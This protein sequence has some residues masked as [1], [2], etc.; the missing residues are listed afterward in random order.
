MRL[1]F[2]TTLSFVLCTHFLSAE[3]KQFM[4]PL[5]VPAGFTVEIAARPPLVEH[6]MLACFDDRGRLFIAESDGQNLKKEELL[7]QRP[8]FVRLLEDTDGDG[9]FDKST[10]FA[11]KMTMPEG[12]LWHDGALYIISAPYLWRLKDTDDD[13]VCDEREKLLGYMEFDGRANQHGPFLGPNGRLYITGGHFGVDFQAKDGSKVGAGH[14]TAG[15]FSCTLDGNDVQV[16]GLG[17]INPV[18]IIFTPE[19]EMISTNAI[20]DSVGGRHD[21]LVHWIHGGLTQRVYGPAYIPDTGVR[22]PALARW[23]QVAPAGLMRYRSTSFGSSY[24]GNLFACQFNSNKVVRVQLQPQGSTYISKTEDFITST[25]RDFHPTD[26]LEDADGS[27]LV[28]DTGGWLSWGCPFSKIAKPEIDGAIYRIRKIQALSPEDPRGKKL[29]WNSP[30]E[31]VTQLDDNRPYVQDRAKELLIKNKDNSLEALKTTLIESKSVRT[32]LHTIWIL[33]RIASPKA[34]ELLH[35][36]LRDPHPSIRQATCRSLGILKLNGSRKDIE[37][38]LLKDAPSVR[39]V[40]AAA[41]G[42]IGHA[43]SVP[44]LLKSLS[45]GSIDNYLLHSHIRALIDIQA[46]RAILNGLRDDH[47]RVRQATLIA[48]D[49]MTN[50][51]LTQEHVTPLLSDPNFEI[52]KLALNI[53][54]KRAWIDSLLSLFK[55]SLQADS[56]EKSAEAT[57]RGTLTFLADKPEI[58]ESVLQSLSSKTTPEKIK[59]LLLESLAQ[60]NWKAPPISFKRVL[61]DFLIYKKES[62]NSLRSKTIELIEVKDCLFLDSALELLAKRKETSKSLKLSCLSILSRH[63]HALNHKS[64]DFLFSILL[65][66]ESALD[67]VRAARAL[68]QANLHRQELNRI[69]NSLKLLD[70]LTFPYL[71]RLFKSQQTVGR[72]T[73]A[74]LAKALLE[75]PALRSIRLNDLNVMHK[76]HHF[77]SDV[78]L[79]LRNRFLVNENQRTEKLKQIESELPVG[80]VE[81]GRSVFESNVSSCTTCHVVGHKG[82]SI[83]PN[84]SKIGSLRRKR[85]LLEAILFPNSTIVNSFESYEV[86]TQDGNIYKG[87]LLRSTLEGIELGFDAATKVKIKRSDIVKLKSLDHSIMPEGYDRILSR[88]NLADLIAYL[89][90]LKG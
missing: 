72:V 89:G 64:S 65:S 73:S 62:E 22:L 33:S 21:A 70:P 56:I 83:G 17:P 49:Q 43:D 44:A 61:E 57:I 36:G 52:Q 67:R 20:F 78:L 4:P 84:L 60:S 15:V 55:N 5:S 63:G 77:E 27:L 54:Q 19:G 1:I 85:D 18:E 13:G 37:S 34:K 31:I 24:Q 40:A 53:V 14:R 69:L 75:S 8:R 41:L 79:K 25:D 39:R 51:I 82:R 16:V 88:Q 50:S 32:R 47:F 58:Q 10:I 74:E 12:A 38:L 29:E 11:D 28:L 90:S 23:S 46:P 76:I 87:I 59:A 80:N 42:R 86:I 66:Q 9:K 30:T 2:C 45:V 26:V 3:D 81:R 71:A 68:S 48:L 35:R 6:P 7:K